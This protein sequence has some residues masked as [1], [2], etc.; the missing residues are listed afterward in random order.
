MKSLPPPLVLSAVADR[1]DVILCDVWGVV[2]DGL[3][4]RPE[5]CAA[6]AT[7][8]GGGG[9]VVL[10]SN[11][12]RP[13][14]AVEAQLDQVGVPHAAWDAFV[15]SGD[16]TAAEIGRR[17][18]R[19]IVHIGPPRDHALFAPLGV[20]L[21]DTA[22]AELA[23]VTGLDDD[24]TET[25]EDYRGRLAALHAHGLVMICANP[26]RVVE[27]GD[28]LIWCAGALADL[29]VGLG[30]EVVYAGKPYPAI[31][32]AALRLAAERR[33]VPV[34]EGRVLAVGD[35]VATDVA[36]AIA[37]GLPCLFVSGG[38]HGRELGDPPA[39]EI[40]ARLFGTLPHPP[41]GWTHRLRWA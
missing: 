37:A 29:Y 25:P 1:Y 2:H 32:Q 16:L 15:T 22:D 17:G 30:G 5:A 23:V 27:R 9:T 10:I 4:A 24:E 6:L 7:F 13:A 41:L 11:S 28:R 21:V 19:R 26:D 33:G 34:A 12:P 40:W 31:Y 20:D 38:I 36:G 39:P 14:K 35:G 3:R 8:R 18:A